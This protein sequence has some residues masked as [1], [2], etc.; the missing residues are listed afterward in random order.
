MLI[1]DGLDVG[2][3]REK[4]VIRGRMFLKCCGLHT[5]KM[6]HCQEA[7]GRLQKDWGCGGLREN[8]QE[9]SFRHTK[10]EMPIRIPIKM[11]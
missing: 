11:S 10:F 9:L 7:W 1:A 5:W 4:C 6:E 3:E 8:D 2:S